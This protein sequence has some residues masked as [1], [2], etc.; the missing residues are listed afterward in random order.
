MPR[1][2]D[3][4]RP[5]NRA[6]LVRRL[7]EH[8]GLRRFRPGQERAVHSAIDGRD[9]LVIM[10]TGSGKS[11]CFQLP[12]L[13]VDGANVVVSPLI[14]LMK[15]QA[16]AL[17]ADGD[18]LGGRQQHPLSGRAARG[19]NGHRGR[20]R[21][22]FIY[23]LRAQRVV[24]EDLSGHYHLREPE[25]TF[26]DVARL[27][28]GYEERGELDMVRLRRMVDDAET[29][30]CRWAFLLDYFGR[31]NDPPATCGHCVNCKAGW[32]A[33]CDNEIGAKLAG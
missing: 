8:L 10:P 25:R 23:F 6:E 15:D 14:A 3:S 21:V 20:G 31:E 30:R 11:L 13:V 7:R 28:R 26:D 29:R 24:D 12:A 27:A 1:V 19:R 2:R 17:G 18:R 22:H 33:A 32:S 16:E 9:T 5:C 4:K